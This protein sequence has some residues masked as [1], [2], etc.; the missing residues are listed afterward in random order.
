M[1]SLRRL[2]PQEPPRRWR[3]PAA[4]ELRRK[5]WLLRLPNPVAEESEQ[6][7]R[8]H[9]RRRHQNRAAAEPVIR[10]MQT[11]LRAPP[12]NLRAHE[13]LVL[14]SPSPCWRRRLLCLE[15]GLNECGVAVSGYLGLART[16]PHRTASGR[17]GAVVCIVVRL[18]WK[19]VDKRPIP[20]AFPL[21]KRGMLMAWFLR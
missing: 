18:S 15:S 5:R 3:S 13:A 12:R 19:D 4:V 16:E 21:F 1:P 6:P 11:P 14:S 9:L 8:P 20:C 17:K 10:L 2:W 7:P